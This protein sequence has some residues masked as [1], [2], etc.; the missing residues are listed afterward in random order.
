[1][2]KISVLVLAAA[3]MPLSSWGMYATAESTTAESTAYSVDDSTQ[4]DIVT[5]ESADDSVDLGF[6]NDAIQ[7]MFK[8]L[9]EQ[10]QKAKEQLTPEQRDELDKLE[11]ETK[12]LGVKL[13][14]LHADLADFQQT[15]AAQKAEVKELKAKLASLEQQKAALP[16]VGE[17][18]EESSEQR[19]ERHK[20]DTDIAVTQALLEEKRAVKKQTKTKIKEHEVELATTE[21]EMNKKHE[22]MPEFSWGDENFDFESLFSDDTASDMSFTEQA[23]AEE[24]VISDQPVQLTEE[25]HTESVDEF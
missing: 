22:A 9:E 12:E 21:E 2:K 19:E 25:I 13:N 18:E 23:P 20:L 17:G 5:V 14:T 24:S 1:M 8:Q 16:V 4:D 15:K 3:L 7:A 11:E 10:M 6:D